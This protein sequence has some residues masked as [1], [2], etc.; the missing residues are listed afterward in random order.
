[1]SV[2]LSMYRPRGSM[3]SVVALA[4]W[5]LVFGPKGCDGWLANAVMAAGAWL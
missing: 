1:M 3:E 4:A 2:L 5:L